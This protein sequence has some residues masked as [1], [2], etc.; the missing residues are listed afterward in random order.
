M[1]DFE[2]GARAPLRRLTHHYQDQDEK[3]FAS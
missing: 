1:N 3:V 2:C